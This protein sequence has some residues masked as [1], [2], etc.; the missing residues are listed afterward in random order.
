[1]VKAGSGGSI[2]DAAGNVWTINAAGQVT[3]NGVADTTTANVAEIAYVNG[4]VWQ[5]VSHNLI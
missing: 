3:V 5:Q 2:H 4:L 1:V